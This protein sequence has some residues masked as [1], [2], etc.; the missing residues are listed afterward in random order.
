MCRLYR[1]KQ[2]T[3][4][5]SMKESIF[6]YFSENLGLFRFVSVSYET[7]LLV[8]V[9]SIYVRNSET[10]RNL[11]LL[12][13]RNKPKQILFRFLT[14]RNRSCFSLFRFERIFFRGHPS[15]VDRSSLKSE[16][17]RFL[18]NSASSCSVQHIEQNKFIKFTIDTN[19]QV[20]PYRDLYFSER[21]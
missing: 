17:W 7:F 15:S 1:I 6:G 18:E 21:Q 9:V 19:I 8:S 13:S 10:N 2:K 3:H 11:L 4:P 20:T 14:N 5:N 12:V 16:A